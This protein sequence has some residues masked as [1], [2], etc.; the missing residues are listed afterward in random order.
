MLDV[1]PL[2][3]SL[4]NPRRRRRPSTDVGGAGAVRSSPSASVLATTSLECWGSVRSALPCNSPV[5]APPKLVELLRRRECS[6]SIIMNNSSFN[7]SMDTSIAM[8]VSMEG[9]RDSIDESSA[10]STSLL[11]LS[12]VSGWSAVAYDW[13]ASFRRQVSQLEADLL[14]S[15]ANLS[16]S[17]DEEMTT[18]NIAHDLFVERC[19]TLY[20]DIQNAI[21]EFEFE[22]QVPCIAS[23][24]E[25]QRRLM[26]Q[27]AVL[28]EGAPDLADIVKLRMNTINKA[29]EQLKIRHDE[30]SNQGPRDNGSPTLQLRKWLQSMDG[31]MAEFKSE[32]IAASD[33]YNA[34]QRLRSDYQAVQLQIESEGQPLLSA[35]KKYIQSRPIATSDEPDKKPDRAI[36]NLAQ[37]EQRFCL[38]WI[39]SLENLER[40]NSC[41]HRLQ[42][43]TTADPE[44]ASEDEEPS[45]KRR[46][47]FSAETEL[48]SILPCFS[49]RST[50]SDVP[51]IPSST[52]SECATEDMADVDVLPNLSVAAAHE[53]ATTAHS[54]DIGYSSG[55]NSPHDEKYPLPESGLV[56]PPESEKTLQR[57]KSTP[58]KRFYKTVPLDDT[59]ATDT[60]G[61]RVLTDTGSGSEFCLDVPSDPLSESM[62]AQTD[63]V[64]GSVNMDP[65]GDFDEVMAMLDGD[66]LDLM[67]ERLRNGTQWRELK[68]KPKRV[69]TPRRSIQ[70]SLRSEDNSREASSEGESDRCSLA[71]SGMNSSLTARKRRYKK[72]TRHSLP[73]GVGSPMSSS[74]TSMKQSLTN[75]GMDESIYIF[76]DPIPD[77]MSQSV[78]ATF[79]GASRK[80]TLPKRKLHRNRMHQSL[81]DHA[82]LAFSMANFNNNVN[83]TMS[84]SFAGLGT[85]L[86]SS[87]LRRSSAAVIP[88]RPSIES[89]ASSTSSGTV[90]ENGDAN[91]E[92]DDYRDP[93]SPPDMSLIDGSPQTASTS[94]SILDA[95]IIEDDFQAQLPVPD[96]GSSD[97]ESTLLESRQTYFQVRRIIN[98]YDALSPEKYEVRKALRQNARDNVKRLTAIVAALPR[99]QMNPDAT[100]IVEH[101]QKDWKHTLEELETVSDDPVDDD[102]VMEEQQATAKVIQEHLKDMKTALSEILA[103]DS[104]TMA[105]NDIE[106]FIDERRRICRTLISRRNGLKDIAEHDT[107]NTFNVGELRNLLQYVE[108]TLNVLS[109]STGELE[110]AFEH[111]Q[112]VGC[113]AEGIENLTAKID[114]FKSGVSSIEVLENAVTQC[115]ERLDALEAIC[116]GLS[117]QFGEI[118]TIT[119]KVR[120]GKDTKYWRQLKTYKSELE[121]LKARYKQLKS[122]Q[123][124][125][126]TSKSANRKKANLPAGTFGLQRRNVPNRPEVNQSIDASPAAPAPR[127]F[128]SRLAGAFR[129][130]RLLQ[131]LLAFSI[132][133]GAAMFLVHMYADE[134]PQNNWRRRF[135]PQ[136]DYVNG[137]PPS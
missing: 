99:T 25:R 37:L 120:P 128:P 14:A 10:Y 131:A 31:K 12:Q 111:Y 63:A 27:A 42:G 45:A 95:T 41:L 24:D 47:T 127:S 86:A 28:A 88:R 107:D 2:S 133:L 100:D 102:V 39:K 70:S 132:F 38:T 110:V 113:I 121:A 57:L 90:Q 65:E 104:R 34:L 16:E 96:S 79:N 8:D 7:A 87:T 56:A 36:R 30:G 26:E 84:S 136:L 29:F 81:S 49:P 78:N 53:W 73:S 21:D 126:A 58:T 125:S 76:N 89:L 72:A 103:A 123:P 48:P 4:P 109:S 94:S 59:G 124:A 119:G 92:W 52:E 71:E 77:A 98:E 115:Q 129:E 67:V 51:L 50:I 116:D 20:N 3:A 108:D 91:Y 64:N 118:A 69:S 114:S 117:S 9:H 80:H 19:C 40:I 130:S 93:P 15:R 13:N 32:L 74:F 105:V 46:R 22:Q 82:D 83:L 5:S 97:V 1:S 101:L 122:A 6:R 137:P 106:S 75:V 134:G 62:I 112:N 135:G 33:S 11:E 68:M 54:Q 44:S 66:D 35:A 43:P 18:K 17:T 55:E 23:L 85:P 61:A 60:E